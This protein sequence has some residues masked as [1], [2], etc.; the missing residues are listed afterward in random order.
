MPERIGTDYKIENASKKDYQGREILELIQNADDEMSKLDNEKRIISITYKDG[1]LSVSNNGEPFNEN[2]VKSLMLAYNSDKEERA[3]KTPVIGN[4]GTGFRAVLSWASKV[5]I[6]SGELHISFSSD[7]SNQVL[8]QLPKSLIKG[9]TAATLAF[10]KWIGDDK[11]E[12]KFDTEIGLC[13]LDDDSVR[14]SINK[15][16]TGLSG[17]ILLFLNYATEISIEIDEHKR[18]FRK[19]VKNK[20]V[21][22]KEYSNETLTNT[23]EWITESVK[24]SYNQSDYYVTVAYRADGNLPEKQVLYS[25]LPTDVA[26][27]LPILLHASLELDG[28]RNRPLKENKAHKEIMAKAAE[29]IAQAAENRACLT[30]PSSFDALKMLVPSNDTTKSDL[31]YFDFWEHLFEERKKKRILPTVNDEYISVTDYPIIYSNPIA[32]HLRGG[33]FKKLIKYTDEKELRDFLLPLDERRIYPFST[34]SEAINKWSKNRDYSLQTIIENCTLIKSLKDEGVNAKFDKVNLIYASDKKLSVSSTNPVYIGVDTENVIPPDFVRMKLIDPEMEARLLELFDVSPDELAEE[35]SKFNLRSFDTSEVIEKMQTSIK[36]RIEQ[37]DIKNA[38][39]CIIKSLIWMNENYEDVIKCD[40]HSDALLLNRS[41]NIKPASTLYLGREYGEIIADDLLKDFD[42]DI[43]VAYFPEVADKY[44]LSQIKKIL[45]KLGVESKPRDAFI[46]IKRLY[47]KIEERY[48]GFIDYFWKKLPYPI[49]F[50]KY[51]LKRES[52]YKY[53]YGRI[54]TL[55][56]LEWILENSD[57]GSIIRWIK[58]DSNLRTILKIGIDKESEINVIFDNLRDARKLYREK[59]PS[60][61]T[62]LFNSIPWITVAGKRYPIS[63]CVLETV[64]TEIAD[65]IVEPDIA[66]YISKEKGSRTALRKACESLLSDVGVCN[67]YGEL[68]DSKM[69]A[70]LSRLA[71]VDDGAKIAKTVYKKIYD[72]CDEE[73]ITKVELDKFVANGK[74]LCQDGQFYAPSECFY[75]ERRAFCK[76]IRDHYHLVDIRTRLGPPRILK[77]FGVKKLDVHGEI[78]GN[79]KLHPV[80]DIFQIDFEHFKKC[81][82]CYRYGN[83]KSKEQDELTKFKDLKVVICEHIDCRINEEI[84]EFDDYDY[85]SSDEKTYYLCLPTSITSY[86]ALRCHDVGEAVANIICEMLNLR[87]EKMSF[88]DLYMKNNADRIKAVKDE[89]EDPEIY[90]TVSEEL[91]MQENNKSDFISVLLSLSPSSEK[92]INEYASVIDFDHFNSVTNA[93]YIIECLIKC[94]TDIFDYNSLCKILPID[95]DEYYIKLIKSF[96]SQF[97]MAYQLRIYHQLKTM[98]VEDKLSFVDKC[99]E[100]KKLIN[101]EKNSVPIEESV[102]FSPREAV[103]SYFSLESYIDSDEDLIKLFNENKVTF[104]KTVTKRD[105]LESFYSDNEITSLLYFGEFDELSRRYQTYV[106]QHEEPV[107]EPDG[108]PRENYSLSTVI[109]TT[110]PRGSSPQERNTTVGFSKSSSKKAENSKNFNGRRGEEIVYYWLKKH[111]EKV[112]WVSENAKKADV[113]PLGSASNG[114]DMYYIED[115]K[116][117]YV[118]VKSTSSDTDRIFFYMSSNELDCAIKNEGSYKLFYVANVNSSN[119]KLYILSDV[120]KD[121]QINPEAFAVESNTEY[122]ISGSIE[123]IGQIED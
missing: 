64:P 51:E 100:Y 103:I 59:T 75:L 43:F 117:V 31:N 12:R 46:E 27:P 118:E 15:Q 112:E 25:Y 123:S 10:P 91:D 116:K 53:L 108:V 96:M 7:Y 109:A 30:K 106:K 38:K 111:Y 102:H 24:G 65:I 36:R 54:H 35:L 121:G 37:K 55:E 67:S 11:K 44:D 85:V 42:D 22:I 92:I 79:P 68:H 93:V 60:M 57:T 23:V 104:E 18:T 21:Q 101:D 33:Y 19:T 63:D 110:T 58:S 71:D 13:V 26:L 89:T 94:N 90:K 84:V 81:A 120:V 98:S 107:P 122:K 6:H 70:F 76:V 72:D 83:N 77:L 41:G 87:E 49:R 80:N 52:R 3:R 32:L 86:N 119:P 47:D 73:K 16:L 62:W 29:L 14:T 99:V 97:E 20:T 4:K 5:V 113:N 74:M 45:I 78:V 34:F 82:Y 95:L 39:Q 61:I 17:E 2:G 28:T 50:E 56:H 1:F 105:F 48:A 115:E 88:R 114:F 69:Y 8:R 9:R 40:L 66:S